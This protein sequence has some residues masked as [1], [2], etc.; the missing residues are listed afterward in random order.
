MIKK[1]WSQRQHN[2]DRRTHTHTQEII[3]RSRHETGNERTKKKVA[4]VLE[5][6]IMCC[7]PSDTACHCTTQSVSKT[8]EDCAERLKGRAR[9]SSDSECCW[10]NLDVIHAF[11]ELRLVDLQPS[12]ASKQVREWPGHAARTQCKMKWKESSI[13]RRCLSGR[14]RHSRHSRT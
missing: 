13:P 3:M 2:T 11:D 5:S 14:A 4:C 9:E 1:E 6:A 10:A 7:I 8:H 12:A